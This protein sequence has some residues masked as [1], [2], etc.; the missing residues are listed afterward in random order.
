MDARVYHAVCSKPALVLAVLALSAP[1][2][3]VLCAQTG[4]SAR[5]AVLQASI[6]QMDRALE[7]AASVLGAG[8]W[9]RFWRVRLPLIAATLVSRLGDAVSLLGWRPPLRTT[10][11]RSR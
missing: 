6:E 3:R 11:V 2:W 9:R 1:P 10:A 4:F 7:E 5:T 8:W